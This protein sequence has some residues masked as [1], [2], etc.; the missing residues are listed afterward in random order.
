MVSRP[1]RFSRSTRSIFD[2]TEHELL[3]S[4]ASSWEIAIKHADRAS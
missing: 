1:E 2:S 3:L 4:A